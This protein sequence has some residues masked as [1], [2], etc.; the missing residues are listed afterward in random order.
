MTTAPRTAQI[1]RAEA[2][3]ADLEARRAANL[4]INPEFGSG[5]LEAFDNQIAAA[6]RLLA[7]LTA[8]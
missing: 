3:L 6:R 2:I 4:A 8:A 1:A 7:R 5:T